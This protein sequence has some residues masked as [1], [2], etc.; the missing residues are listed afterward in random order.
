MWLLAA[1]L[2]GT[3]NEESRSLRML[4][5]AERDQGRGLPVRVQG[6]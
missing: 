2:V 4:L 3:N 6:V 5:E 1:R